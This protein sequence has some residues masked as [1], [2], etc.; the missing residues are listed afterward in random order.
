MMDQ[1][2]NNFV[3]D[4][5]KTYKTKNDEEYIKGLMNIYNKY[6]RQH[7]EEIQENKKKDPETIEELDR[8][9][10]FMEKSQAILQK[11]T[12]TN[13]KKTKEN[14][15]RR[16]QENNVLISDL[17]AT[18]VTKTILV[19]ELEKKTLNIQKLKLEKQ[20]MQ[21]EF[22]KKLIQIEQETLQKVKEAGVIQLGSGLEQD[23]DTIF[24]KGSAQ[25]KPEIYSSEPGVPSRVKGKIYKGT[26]FTRGNK[27]D[28]GKIIELEVSIFLRFLGL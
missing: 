21:R 8:Q 3:N 13:Q 24:R 15:I 25:S 11:T 7:I 17:E 18:R 16:R 27:E 20:K 12:D 23:Q 6:V 19:K 9:L 22:D 28:K 2:I 14:I 5:H 10:Q 4:V 26:P 1:T